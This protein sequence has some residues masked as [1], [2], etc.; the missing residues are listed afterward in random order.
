MAAINRGRETHAHF[1]GTI[2]IYAPPA[3]LRAPQGRNDGGV[4]GESSIYRSVLETRTARKTNEIRVITV[5]RARFRRTASFEVADFEH[6]VGPK[7]ELSSGF[8]AQKTRRR[9]QRT[10]RDTVVY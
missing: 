1:A 10:L 7:F 4:G 9:K 6:R 2:I 8:R 3:G 5:R